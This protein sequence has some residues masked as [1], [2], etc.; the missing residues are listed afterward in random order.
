MRIFQLNQLIDVHALFT[1]LIR[2]K[3][4]IINYNEIF[5]WLFKQSITEIM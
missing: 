4:Y 1:F 2:Q 5:W 3:R